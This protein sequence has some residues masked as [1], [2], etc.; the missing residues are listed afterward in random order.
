MN[1]TLIVGTALTFLV[2]VAS[3]GLAGQG[4][5]GARNT[6]DNIQRSAPSGEKS[7][8]GGSGP[9]SRS[10]QLTEMEEVKP[11]DT[12]HSQSQGQQGARNTPDN[13]QRSAPSGEKSLPGGSGPGSRS[14]QL[15]EMDKVKP[16]DPNLTQSKGQAAEAAKNLKK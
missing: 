2:G 12:I 3:V 13:I 11:K 16:V 9:G 10:D 5:Q 1:K 8:P 6:P 4:Q 15:T 7:L 14:D